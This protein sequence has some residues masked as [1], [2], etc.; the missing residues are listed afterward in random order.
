LPLVRRALALTK[1]AVGEEYHFYANCLTNLADLHAR[2][3][4]IDTATNLYQQALAIRK[5]NDYPQF[6]N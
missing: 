6:A 2:M 1:K 5:K 4:N 3:G